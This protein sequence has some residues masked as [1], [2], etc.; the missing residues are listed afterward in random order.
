MKKSSTYEYVLA[1]F[2]AA[3]IAVLA[4]VTIP[5]P[6]SPVPI[7]GQTLAIGLV[8]TILG[9]KLGTLSVLLYILLGAA[10][11]PVFSGMSGGLGIVVG[12]TGGYI[13]GFLPTAFIMGLYLQKSGLT[14]PH[15]VVANVIGMVVTLAFGT[16]WLKIV[17]DLTW[18]A[19]FMG[20]VAPFIITGLIKAVAAAWLGVVVRRRL[21]TAHLV[22]ATA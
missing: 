2:G 8:V 18:T 10:G 16:V 17:A 13:V 15:A 6:F 11:M 20:G 22:E 14:I 9:A 21:E 19:A 3:I 5:L 12:P 4:Q 7:T 1:A